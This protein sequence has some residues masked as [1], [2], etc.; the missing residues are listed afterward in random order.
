MLIVVAVNT[1]Q[2]PAQVCPNHNFPLLSKTQNITLTN[3]QKQTLAA[4][5]EEY[6]CLVNLS[7][8]FANYGLGRMTTKSNQQQFKITNA[9]R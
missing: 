9:E 5:K 7:P 2:T 1:A 3:L 4:Y 6:C 8:N